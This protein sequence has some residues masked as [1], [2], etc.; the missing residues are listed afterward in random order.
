MLHLKIIGEIYRHFSVNSLSRSGALALEVLEKN[1]YPK[2]ERARWWALLLVFSIL[3]S[4]FIE[5]R[6]YTKGSQSY[7]E[8]NTE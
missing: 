3:I 2:K 1:F 5:L 8:P 6:T 4:N 7:P